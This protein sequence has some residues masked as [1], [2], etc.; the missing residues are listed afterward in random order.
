[1]LGL[2]K[3]QAKTYALQMMSPDGEGSRTGR[4]TSGIMT[5]DEMETSS[6]VVRD[7]KG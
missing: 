1:M 3:A 7:G 4:P 5:A 6:V 2:S